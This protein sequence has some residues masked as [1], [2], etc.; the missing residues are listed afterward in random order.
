MA[1]LRSGRILTLAELREKGLDPDSV[2]IRPIN[3]ILF[4]EGKLFTNAH[5]ELNAPHFYKCNDF[6]G[7]IVPEYFLEFDG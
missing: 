3:Y 7:Y 5:P 1:K 6:N 4:L 2:G